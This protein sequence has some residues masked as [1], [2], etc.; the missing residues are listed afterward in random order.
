MPKP[1]ASVEM[2]LDRAEAVH[3]LE[4]G[5]DGGRQAVRGQAGA[6]D[7]ALHGVRE[8]D[9]VRADVEERAGQRRQPGVADQQ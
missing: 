1:A 5:R 3:E 9:V 8:G 2:A 7:D 6:A 4:D